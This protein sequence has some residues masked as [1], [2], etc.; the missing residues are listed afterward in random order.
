M[1]EATEFFKPDRILE[2]TIV[3]SCTYLALR[4][5]NLELVTTNMLEKV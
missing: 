4:L 3:I 5:L 2:G 1:K